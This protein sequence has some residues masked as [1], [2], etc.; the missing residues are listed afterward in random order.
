MHLFTSKQTILAKSFAEPLGE[1]WQWYRLG[2]GRVSQDTRIWVTRRWGI[3]LPCM[4]YNELWGKDYDVWISAKLT[5]PKYGLS[6]KDGKSDI[7]VDRMVLVEPE[8]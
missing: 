1:G 6:S 4:Y 7:W 3:F 2:C 8:Q 5:G